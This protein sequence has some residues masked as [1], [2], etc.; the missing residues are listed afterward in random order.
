M[1]RTVLIV[2][3]SESIRELVSSVLIQSGYE[4]V[5]GIH[6]KDGLEKLDGLD[7][8]INLIIT[9]LH[10]PVMDG[11]EFTKKVRTLEAYRYLPILILTTESQLEKKLEAKSMGATGWLVKPFEAQRLLKIVSKVI[12]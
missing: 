2:D 10:M 12:R 8:K 11:M 7:K 1:S 4:V 5:K 3:D 6:G 9:D